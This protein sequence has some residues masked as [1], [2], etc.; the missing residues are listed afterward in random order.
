MPRPQVQR[1]S[2][3]QGKHQ[4]ALCWGEPINPIPFAGAS[5]PTMIL[6]LSAWS[7]NYPW[8]LVLPWWTILLT[9]HQ[10]QYMLVCLKVFIR[11]ILRSLGFPGGTLGKEPPAN[12]G[13]IRDRFDSWVRNIPWRRAWQPSSILAWR[14]PWTVEPG[15]LQFIG[16]QRVRHD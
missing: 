1:C 13:Y 3:L 16:S 2:S 10:I 8:S 7:W 9:G 11:C 5:G 4:P 6:L 15:G 12:A 14:I